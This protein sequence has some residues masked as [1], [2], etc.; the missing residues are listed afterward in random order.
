[1]GNYTVQNDCQAIFSAR[2][3]LNCQLAHICFEAREVYLKKYK[4]LFG[5]RKDHSI[6]HADLKIDPIPFRTSFRTVRPT[7]FHAFC[8]RNSYSETLT[9][10]RSQPHPSVSPSSGSSTSEYP[11]DMSLISKAW[12]A[13]LHPPCADWFGWSPSRRT[14]PNE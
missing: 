9:R 5:E 8:W 10:V 2:S 7:S 1:M 12:D 3:A 13:D 6:I 4:P 14:Y 11:R